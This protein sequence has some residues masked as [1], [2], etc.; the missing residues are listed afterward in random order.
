[1]WS[2][3]QCW[4]NRDTEGKEN[5][6]LKIYRKV[7]SKKVKWMFKRGVRS[8][9]HLDQC[10]EYPCRIRIALGAVSHKHRNPTIEV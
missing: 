8:V 9:R 7:E 6:K 1:M 5:E 2:A 10:R 4:K 3:V